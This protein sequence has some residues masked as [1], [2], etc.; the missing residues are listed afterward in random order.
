MTSSADTSVNSSATPREEGGEPISPELVLVDPELARIERARLSKTA[1]SEW[2]VDL[3][4]SRYPVHAGGGDP[5]ST[6]V[7][8]SSGARLS[9]AAARSL[10]LLAALLV[11]MFATGIFVSRLVTHEHTSASGQ[12]AAVTSAAHSGAIGASTVSGSSGQAPGISGRASAEAGAERTILSLV[13][14]SP[15]RNLPPQLVDSSTGLLKNNV[16]ARCHRSGRSRAF[17]CVI[18]P[19]ARRAGEGLYVRYW[20]GRGPHGV[21]AWYGY[22]EG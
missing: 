1:D 14:R 16:H 11:A 7:L 3:S 13:L 6:N 4:A 9:V 12:L 15:K 17:L 8:A 10:L 19:P 21:F 18:Q 5:D 22:R 2:R 20:P